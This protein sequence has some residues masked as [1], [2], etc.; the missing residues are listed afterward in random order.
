MKLKTNDGG[1][2]QGTP[3][4][5][6]RIEQ[7]RDVP[8]GASALLLP[9]RVCDLLDDVEAAFAVTGVRTPAWPGRPLDQSPAPEEYSRCLD[10]GKFRILQARIDAWVGVL[11]K[12]GWAQLSTGRST[13]RRGDHG[14]SQT[15]VVLRPTADAEAGGAVPLTFRV[16]DSTDPEATLNVTVFAGDPPVE[17]AEVPGCGCDACDSGSTWLLEELDKWALSVVDGSLIVDLSAKLQVQT[18]FGGHGSS[19]GSDRDS[20]SS[21]AFTAAPWARGWDPLPIPDRESLP[22][23]PDSGRGP[24]VLAGEWVRDLIRRLRGQPRSNRGWTIYSRVDR[25]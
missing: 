1:E 16:Y 20:A 11:V 22:L 14:Q 15:T 12:R 19:G 7:L 18:S 17:L 4:W 5:H 23:P 3:W 6:E 9:D 24:R 25:S 8:E 2:S 13:E 21:A 10:S